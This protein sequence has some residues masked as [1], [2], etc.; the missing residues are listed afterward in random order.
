MKRDNKIYSEVDWFVH[1]GDNFFFPTKGLNGE[2]MV[3]T[4]KKL[5]FEVENAL[6]RDCK[7]IVPEGTEVYFD[8]SKFKGPDFVKSY[9]SVV[10][11]KDDNVILSIFTKRMGLNCFEYQA[12]VEMPMEEFKL[13]KEM[14]LLS[15]IEKKFEI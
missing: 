13:A 2:D 9:W 14:K 3:E 8:K 5:G 6:E 10:V 4:Y 15:D 11:D 1:N 12:R 7:V